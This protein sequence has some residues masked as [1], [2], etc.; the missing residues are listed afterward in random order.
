MTATYLHISFC[1]G[2]LISDLQLSFCC[3]TPHTKLRITDIFTYEYQNGLR[4]KVTVYYGSRRLKSKL[5]P[6][7][8]HLFVESTSTHKRIT[9]MKRLVS[10]KIWL[11]CSVSQE[12][13]GV[14]YVG[15]KLTSFYAVFIFPNS[16]N[17]L[18]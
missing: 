6:L 17:Y 9:V 4:K 16:D 18:I 2:S 1:C 10:S 3:E 13:R 15:V 7:C 5:D 14:E 12:L 8:Y 11:Q